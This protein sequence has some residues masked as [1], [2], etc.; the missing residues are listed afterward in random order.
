MHVPSSSRYSPSAQVMVGTNVGATDGV[1]VG[2]RRSISSHVVPIWFDCTLKPVAMDS[3][4]AAISVGRSSH[5]SLYCR[6]KLVSMLTKSPSCV[7]ITEVRSLE[8]KS[9]SL[10]S[11]TSWPSSVGMADVKLFVWTKK[12]ASSFDIR[13]SSVGMG[14]VSLFELRSNSEVKLLQPAPS[15]VGM[16]PVRLFHITRPYAPAS[17]PDCSLT[18]LASSVG[19]VDVK[20]FRPRLRSVTS[21]SSPNSVGIEPVKSSSL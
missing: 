18:M 12:Y 1:G 11:F 5:I 21:V 15:S 4:S 13:P 19:I 16:F 3:E 7:G 14:P 17:P 8:Y 9:N 20:L 10:D 6:S 2:T